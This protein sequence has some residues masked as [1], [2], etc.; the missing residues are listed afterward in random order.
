MI[1]NSIQNQVNFGYNKQLND[2]VNKKLEHAKGNKELAQDLLR[3]N[4]LCIDT[5][6]KLRK[7]EKENNHRLFDIYESIFM[8]IKPLTSQLLEERFPLLKY[9]KT[10]M[11]TYKKEAEERKIRN[12]FHW[13]P[14]TI[15]N[16]MDDDEFEA[17]MI[18]E[19][20]ELDGKKTPDVVPPKPN[21]TQKSEKEK[22]D[23][24][25]LEK[26][27]P[28]EYSPTGFASLGG[29]QALKDDL[30]DKIIFPLREPELAKLDEIEYGKK[31]PRGVLLY[32]PPGC[33][34]TVMMQAV[35][36]ESKIPLY[37]LKVAKTGS[38]YIN[39]SATNI[40]AAFD[41]LVKEVKESGQPAILAIDEMETLTRKRE[42]DSSGKEDDKVVGTLLQ[43]I[44]EARGKNIIVLGATNH[45]D[46]LDDAIKSRFDNK[47]YVGLPDK[48][49][50]KDVLKIHLNKISKGKALAGNEEELD[51]L[52]SMT[53]GFSNRDLTILLSKAALIARKDGRRDIKADDFVV[54]I[55]ENQNM[56]VKESNYMDKQ[57][58]PVIGFS[59][60]G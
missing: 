51:R 57:T 32:G 10:E 9:K 3:L 50:R 37:S 35:S 20:G 8:T 52:A 6:D 41:Y 49:L 33:G 27:E 1:I 16:L 12:E 53:A 44:E 4:K 42:A 30:Y 26:F 11:E 15:E 19:Y 56:K 2:T 40:Q 48:E 23:C 21:N 13:L 60:L 55:A 46:L 25:L 58:R 38:K 24:D 59:K 54:P 39:E 18:K 31:N 22:T 43:I 45:F 34:K 5:E 47:V 29:M 17:E 36:G 14:S 28:T 7:A